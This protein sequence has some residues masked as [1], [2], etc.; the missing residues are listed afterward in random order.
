MMKERLRDLSPTPG[1]GFGFIRD[2]EGNFTTI[3]VPGSIGTG[4]T[5]IKAGGAVTGSYADSNNV[6]H[7]FV[8]RANGTFIS[9]DPP[10]SIVTAALSLNSRGAVTGSYPDASQNVH[11]FVRRPRGEIVSFDGPETTLT[12]P[13]SINDAGAI[14][15]TFVANVRAF[16]F[17]RDPQGKFTSFDTGATNTF[18]S[19]I[20]SEGAITGYHT[21]A[22]MV[23]GSAGF[24]RSAEGTITSFVPPFCASNTVPTGINDEGVITGSCNGPAPLGLFVGWVRF[25]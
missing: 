20:N 21:P 9:F 14:T 17:V 6:T 13:V 25:P 16:G 7:G 24:V 18:S 22:P 11:G 12:A 23:Y 15:G 5:S 2:P 3:E 4:A 19:S 1:R 8:R 10:G